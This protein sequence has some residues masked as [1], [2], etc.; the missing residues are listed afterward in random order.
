METKDR[1]TFLKLMGTSAFAAALPLNLS[2]V[3][4]IPAHNRTGTIED[5]E[6][7]VCLMQENR[8]FDHYFG[9]MRG[10]RGFGDR[11]ALRMNNNQDIFHQPDP[12]RAEGADV[13][14]DA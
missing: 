1:R 11:A 2:Q 10:V 6:H 14:R 13:V 9:T 5:V 3:L 7:I 4:S 12:A 8:A